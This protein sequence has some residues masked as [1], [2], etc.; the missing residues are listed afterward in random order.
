MDFDSLVQAQ[1][2][3]GTAAVIVMDKSVRD[4]PSPLPAC[5]GRA[6]TF[7]FFPQTDIVKAIARL[8]EFYKHESCGQCTPCREGE[9]MRLG[10]MGLGGQQPVPWDP[11]HLPLLVGVDWMNKVMAR[12]VRGDAQVA[13]ID[14]LWEISKQIEGHT[15]CALGDG[16]AWPVQVR[17]CGDQEGDFWGDFWLVLIPALLIPPRL[18][19]PGPNP[20]LSAGAGGQD[21]ALRG[22]QSSSGLGVRRQR[23]RTGGWH[24]APPCL[25]ASW[26]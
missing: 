17:G 12:F 5:P 2:G 19:S 9:R 24:C 20:P 15:I 25:G 13:E 1:S 26:G 10:R 23:W 22:G 8:I 6:L 11:H 21:A 7:P 3:L 4:E 14:A 16:A 18:L